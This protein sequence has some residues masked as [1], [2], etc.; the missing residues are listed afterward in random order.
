MSFGSPTLQVSFCSDWKEICSLTAHSGRMSTLLLYCT[1]CL[2]TGQQ[3]NT[4]AG[5]GQKNMRLSDRE[6]WEYQHTAVAGSSCGVYPDC[7]CW[8]VLAGT[9]PH[10]ASRHILAA[11]PLP[12]NHKLLLCAAQHVPPSPPPSLLPGGRR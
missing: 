3:R 9:H 7:P 5:H 2:G 10:I 8:R 11:L 12:H 1:C 4:V 6:Q